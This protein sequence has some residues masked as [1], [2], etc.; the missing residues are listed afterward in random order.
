MS[1]PP[2]ASGNAG[3]LTTIENAA[4]IGLPPDDAERNDDRAPRSH[5]KAAG[6]ARRAKVDARRP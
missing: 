6:G 3:L 5:G 2:P 4:P 1:D